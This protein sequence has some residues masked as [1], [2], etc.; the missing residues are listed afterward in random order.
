MPFFANASPRQG[1]PVHL[2]DEVCR[3]LIDQVATYLSEAPN[4]FHGEAGKFIAALV[5]K[6]PSWPSAVSVLA[7]LRFVSSRLV[8]VGAACMYVSHRL[9]VCCTWR[10]G[11]SLRCDSQ[12]S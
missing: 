12:M 6:H 2:S 4:V 10:L 5:E 1:Q 11:V 3:H 7:H 8:S 9:W